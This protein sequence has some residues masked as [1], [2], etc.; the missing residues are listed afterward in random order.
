MKRESEII[1][2]C[3]TRTGFK[4]VPAIYACEPCATTHDGLYSLKD[5]KGVEYDRV[6]FYYSI[7]YES[8]L[9]DITYGRAMSG[10]IAIHFAHQLIA[11]LCD[12]QFTTEHK[13]GCVHYDIK[14]ENILVTGGGN[15]L[16]FADF[17]IS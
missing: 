8:D 12:M 3:Q 9:W 7:E 10:K 17:G 15:T 16:R 4:G 6:Y 1:D 14:P 5:S 11:H 13:T 2:S